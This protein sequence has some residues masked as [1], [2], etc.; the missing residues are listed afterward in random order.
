MIRKTFALVASWLSACWTFGTLF[1]VSEPFMLSPMASILAGGIATL[2]SILVT[3]QISGNQ[4]FGRTAIASSG[5]I[6][7][8]LTTLQ[9]GAPHPAGALAFLAAGAFISRRPAEIR[10]LGIHQLRPK[11]KPRVHFQDPG[12][13]HLN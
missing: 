12:K 13:P 8:L 4:G 10:A 1:T 6:L 7:L 11:R 9:P 5:A 2:P 3:I